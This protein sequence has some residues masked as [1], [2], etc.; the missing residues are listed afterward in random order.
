[1]NSE[2]HIAAPLDVFYVVETTGHVS[3]ERH[4]R[5]R[6]VLFE[7]PSQAN[8]ERTRLQVANTCGTFSV[9]KGTTYIEPA[10]WSYD[11]VM[12]DGTVI[13]SRE[14]NLLPAT[15]FSP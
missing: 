4:H 9:W 1:M 8:K 12:A 7:T 14:G 11:V 2:Q 10:E 13:R 5:I 15:K 3:G 6:S